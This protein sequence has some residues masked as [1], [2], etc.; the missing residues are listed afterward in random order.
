MFYV[1]RFYLESKIPSALCGYK[2]KFYCWTTDPAQVWLLQ[3]KLGQR[4]L[5]V[6][7]GNTLQQRH[8]IALL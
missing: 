4:L 6:T 8:I 3:Q 7:L 1:L 2:Q 5:L